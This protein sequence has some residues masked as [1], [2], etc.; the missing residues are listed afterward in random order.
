MGARYQVCVRTI[1][2]WT[3]DGTLPVYK[4]GGVVRYHVEECD[5]AFK[6]FR[7]ESRWEKSQ[8]GDENGD[9]V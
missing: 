9:D 6:K 1:D 8:D 7:T 5:A 3:Q 4:R 2:Y